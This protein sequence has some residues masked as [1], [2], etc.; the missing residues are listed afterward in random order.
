MIAGG[1]PF[2]P[3]LTAW[4]LSTFED[5]DRTFREFCA[6]VHSFETM[7]GDIAAIHDAN[8]RFARRFLDHPLRRIR[9]WAVRE[10]RAE[11]AEAAAER[12]RLDE[13]ELH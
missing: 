9:E 3:S 1:E 5:D 12:E 7:R 10:E 8:A 2:V 4:V 13:E 11:I 6:G